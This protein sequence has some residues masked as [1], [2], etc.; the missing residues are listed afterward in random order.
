MDGLSRTRH[1]A[2]GAVIAVLCSFAH[3]K[4]P[5]VP[6]GG[7][8]A[9]AHGGAD[10]SMRMEMRGGGRY[11]GMAGA[12]V[13][14][15]ASRGPIAARDPRMQ[16]G[17]MFADANYSYGYGNYKSGMRRVGGPFG[18]AA[19][20]GRMQYAGAITPISAEAR[21]VPRSQQNMPMRNGSIRA[22]VTRYNEERGAAR[23]MQRPSDDPRQ[24]EG[25]P[26]RN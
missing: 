18:F 24:S 17:A 13:G 7:A 4:G 15:R 5:N 10:R 8:A 14:T 22:D 16:R 20:R 21:P 1:W 2:W 23:A 26:Y 9:Y 25:S 6:H 11:G 12:P 19:E 3:A